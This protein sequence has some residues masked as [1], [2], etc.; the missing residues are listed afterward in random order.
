MSLDER[1]KSNKGNSSKCNWKGL[2]PPG[3]KTLR[4]RIDDSVIW[5]DSAGKLV[6]RDEGGVPVVK[7][8]ARS[9]AGKKNDTANRHCPIHHEIM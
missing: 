2:R 8:K 1:C 6:R 4:K 3:C 9:K 7:P 5:V